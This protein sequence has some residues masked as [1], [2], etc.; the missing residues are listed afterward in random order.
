LSYHWTNHT[1]DLA[2]REHVGWR[3]FFEQAPIAGTAR[4]HDHPLAA[5]PN[6]CPDGCDACIRSGA[7]GDGPVVDDELRHSVVC[8]LERHIAAVQ[9]HLSVASGHSRLARFHLKILS[10]AGRE[11]LQLRGQAFGL[12]RS[13]VIFVVQ[14]LAM[15]VADLDNIGVDQSQPFDARANERPR[16]RDAESATAN[17]GHTALSPARRVRHS[18]LST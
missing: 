7:I 13:S 18:E 1:G 4:L 14:D 12:D 15:Q 17:H 10:E 11:R 2:R 6:G 5:S 16:T 8:A 3:R 9:Q